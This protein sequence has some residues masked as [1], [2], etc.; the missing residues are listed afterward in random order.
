MNF[1]I[2]SVKTF[3]QVVYTAA[4][5]RIFLQISGFIVALV[6]FHGKYAFN[7]QGIILCYVIATALSMFVCDAIINPFN[8]DTILRAGIR[9]DV[10]DESVVEEV[11]HDTAFA[12]II[13]KICD[14]GGDDFD[15]DSGVGGESMHTEENEDNEE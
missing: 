3:V 11:L 1:I 6:V 9:L 5:V 14:L 8:I 2:N 10:Q 12:P 4:V 15:T 13:K 7:L